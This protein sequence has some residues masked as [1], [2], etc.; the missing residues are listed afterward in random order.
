MLG[1]AHD[2]YHLNPLCRLQLLFLLST[3]PNPSLPKYSAGYI[4]YC[5]AYLRISPAVFS[6]PVLMPQHLSYQAREVS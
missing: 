6:T 1:A 5:R 2:T 4:T 3:P